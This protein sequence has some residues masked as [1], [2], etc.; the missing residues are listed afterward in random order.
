ME[1]TTLSKA[2]DSKVNVEDDKVIVNFEAGST[3]DYSKGID[4]MVAK[5]DG[6]K[7]YAEVEIDDDDMLDNENE[8]PEAEQ[9]HYDQLKEMII[10]QAKENDIDVNRL[11][12]WW[13]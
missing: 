7:L 13:D 8:K 11:R 3:S 5:V 9:R 10:E 1:R 2:D 4:F 12:F 6:I